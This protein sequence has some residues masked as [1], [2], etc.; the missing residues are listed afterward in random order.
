[1][2]TNTPLNPETQDRIHQLKL[3][4]DWHA[5]HF[6]VPTATEEPRRAL[7]L[8]SVEKLLLAVS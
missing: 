7:N 1:M 3:G 4:V 2:K 8:V 5:D 6:R